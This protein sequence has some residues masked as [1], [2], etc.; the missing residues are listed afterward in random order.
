VPPQAPTSR[1]GCPLVHAAAAF[2]SSGLGDWR[3]EE[4]KGTRCAVGSSAEVCCPYGSASSLHPSLLDANRPSLS[5]LNE[6]TYSATSTGSLQSCAASPTRR[7]VSCSTRKCAASSLG[8]LGMRQRGGAAEGIG[9]HVGVE[10]TYPPRPSST[11][12]PCTSW[13]SDT[14][15]P[16]FSASPR[17]VPAPDAALRLLGPHEAR[18]QCH[19]RL[20]VQA[21][22]GAREQ[23]LRQ[24]QLVAR[25]RGRWSG[26]GVCRFLECV[27]NPAAAPRRSQR[28]RLCMAP[29]TIPYLPVHTST[30]NPT[31]RSAATRPLVVTRPSSSI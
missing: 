25:L 13:H 7:A 9:W 30:P 24:H 18:R 29:T 26:V 14:R 2:M 19:E 10:C 8:S 12:K 16:P 23:Q 27:Q 6:S 15:T 20:Q 4:K 5:H 28:H 22:E 21:A 11:S 1:N 17:N 31:C 3:S